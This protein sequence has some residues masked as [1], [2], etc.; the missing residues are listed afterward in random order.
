LPKQRKIINPAQGG[1]WGIVGGTFDP[2]HFGHLIMAEAIMHSLKADGML[3]VPAAAHPFK[4]N[5][6]LSDW[7]HR[8]E[9]TR[10]AIENNPRFRLEKPPPELKYTIDLIDYIRSRYPAAD[11]F[12]PVGSD[13]VDE[14][15]DWYKPDEIE[16]SIRIVVAA[17]PGYRA[18]PRKHNMLSGAEW[19]MIPQYDLSSTEIRTRVQSNLSIRYM[20]PDAVRQYIIEKRLYVE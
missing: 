7:E 6:A 11:L 18:G 14:F 17:R 16:Q 10:L 19:V 20:I 2:I 1:L 9:M 15:D 13:I 8:F 5:G 12:L 4:S 3:F